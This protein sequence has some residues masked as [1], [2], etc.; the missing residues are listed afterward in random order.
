M[1]SPPGHRRRQSLL[2][3][4][5]SDPRRRRIHPNPPPRPRRRRSLG[6]VGESPDSPLAPVPSSPRPGS[7]IPYRFAPPT[8]RRSSSIMGPPWWRWWGRTV[9]R[10][11]A[12]GGWACSFRPSRQT[13]SGCSRSTTSF[14]SASLGSPLTPRRCESQLPNSPLLYTRA[15][16]FVS[17]A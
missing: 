16:A 13:S 7:R 5:P 9:S 17:A 1:I 11:P 10:S 8:H 15:V 14:T 3:Q 4:F 6:H 12:T 2:P